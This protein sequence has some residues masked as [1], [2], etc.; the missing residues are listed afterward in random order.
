MISITL[1]IIIVSV[2]VSIMAFRD[3]NLME[4]LIFYP[5]AVR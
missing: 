3:Y 4:K 5:P 2:I 1:F